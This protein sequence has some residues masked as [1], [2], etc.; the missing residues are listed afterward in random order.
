MRNRWWAA[1]GTAAAVVTLAACG[2]SGSPHNSSTASGNQAEA[3]AG[4]AA[5][6]KTASTS[7]GKVLTNSKG[8]TLYWFA[9]DTATKSKCNGSCASYWPPV[10]GSAKAAASSSLS[11]T[12]ATIKRSDGST[13][14]TYMGH[15]LYTYTGDSSAGQTKGNGINLSGGR[16]YA[17]TPSGA[18]LSSGGSSGGSGG[19]GYGGGGYG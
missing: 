3:P 16:W 17:M 2:S 6:I 4:S 8:H 14:L 18:K 10:P 15:P 1:A 5:S 13:Q 11:G 7:I 12:F 9:L 19:G